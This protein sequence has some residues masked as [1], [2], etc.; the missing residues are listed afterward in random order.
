MNESRDRRAMGWIV[1]G[2]AL[3]GVAAGLAG[4]ALDEGLGQDPP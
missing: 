4:F 2:V 1:L 3:V